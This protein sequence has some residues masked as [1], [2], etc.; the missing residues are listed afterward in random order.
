MKQITRLSLIAVA[1]L[2]LSAC[3]TVQSGQA[4]LGANALYA[5]ACEAGEVAVNAGQL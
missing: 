3:T 1:S 5:S 2:Q 4:L